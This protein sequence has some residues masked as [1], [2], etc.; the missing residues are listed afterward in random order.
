[1]PPPAIWLFATTTLVC[2][3]TAWAQDSHSTA[4]AGTDGR[5]ASKNF[6]RSAKS[7]VSGMMA[8]GG[9]LTAWRVGRY[10]T[11]LGVMATM[12]VVTAGTTDLLSQYVTQSLSLGGSE[13]G[14][15]AEYDNRFAY[16]WRVVR[17]GWGSLVARLGGDIE[18]VATPH[19]A[20][21]A[22]GP[23]ADMGY[24]YVSKSS[25]LDLGWRGIVSV[26]PA[27]FVDSGQRHTWQWFSTGPH[28]GARVG[29]L[30]FDGHVARTM[31]GQVMRTEVYADLCGVTSIILCTRVH[32]YRYDGL[33]GHVTLLGLFI[34]VGAT[35]TNDKK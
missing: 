14:F 27:I 15:Q 13:G 12:K 24:Q 33:T 28:L 11:E 23:L 7:E 8:F 18:L 34:G 17:S 32:E 31:E 29:P 1:M 30:F 5:P 16:G 35:N 4:E 20:T 2:T 6:G 25:Y 21:G 9:Q 19:G 26:M 10:G 3:T 22:L